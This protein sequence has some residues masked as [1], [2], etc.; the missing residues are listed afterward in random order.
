[1]SGP[2]LIAKLRALSASADERRFAA[3]QLLMLY[4][5]AKARPGGTFLELGTDRGQ[6]SNAILAACAETGGRL[7]SVDVRDC[8]GA[9]SGPHWSFVQASSLDRAA[10]LAAAP[11]LAEGIDLLYVDSLHTAEHVEREIRTWF[12][13]VRQGGD[14]F[15][16]DVD[17]APYLAGRR[18]D[19]AKME[20]ANRR[21]RALIEHVFQSNLDR[22]ELALFLGSTGLAR[23]RKRAALGEGLHPAS[24]P[25]RQRH[26]AL[27]ARVTGRLRGARYVHKGDGSDFIWNASGP[28][29]H[30]PQPEDGRR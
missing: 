19:N 10:I 21:I 28:R 13:L 9:A 20:I 30:A 12:D 23:L 24:P 5:A 1:M 3:A 25:P 16:D 7:V 26:S 2:D 29:A 27:L 15:F 8:A 14:I 22:T 17:S 6:A 4:E 18:K 11:F